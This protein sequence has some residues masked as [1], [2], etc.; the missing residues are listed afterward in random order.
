MYQLSLDVTR[1]LHNLTLQ[2][3]CEKK[4]KVKSPHRSSRPPPPVWVSLR[5][6]NPPR[7]PSL[8]LLLAEISIRRMLPCRT[9]PFRLRTASLRASKQDRRTKPAPAKTVLY[10]GFLLVFKRSVSSLAT[11]TRQ[12]MHARGNKTQEEHKRTTFTPSGALAAVVLWSDACVRVWVW[13]WVRRH[14]K[15]DMSTLIA[16]QSSTSIRIP[17][18]MLP[19]C[20]TEVHVHMPWSQATPTETTT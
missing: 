18:L 12:D 3:K 4:K 5:S 19:S 13:V 11:A 7:G 20:Y 6:L 16:I 8:F 2:K 9:V 1:M 10:R 17:L 15:H 14:T